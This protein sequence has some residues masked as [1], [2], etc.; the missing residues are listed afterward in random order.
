MIHVIDNFLP[1][2]VFLELQEHCK[3]E[4]WNVVDAGEKQFSTI[5]VPESVEALLG[6][7]GNDI[8]LTFIRRAYKGFDNDL[9]IHCDGIIMNQETTYASVLYINN[10]GECTP[11]GTAFYDHHL[12]GQRFNQ[13]SEQEFNRL[14]L[15][16]SNDESKWEK[17]D[18]VSARPNRLLT[19]E[20]KMFHA[21]FPKEI[22][23]GERIVLVCFYAKSE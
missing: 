18:F 1:E 20:S 13:D 11:N 21:K 9:R 7:P 23:F 5:S 6:L 10:D 2:T 15:E 3:K 14:I 12:H 8:V 22:E 19:Y 17:K 4:K 16:D